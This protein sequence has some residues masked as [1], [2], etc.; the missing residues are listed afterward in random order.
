MKYKGRRNNM[1]ELKYRDAYILVELSDVRI[2]LYSADKV[3]FEDDEAYLEKDMS[4]SALGT[5]SNV[6]DYVL[7]VGEVLDQLR[8]DGVGMAAVDKYVFLAPAQRYEFDIENGVVVSKIGDFAIV[9]CGVIELGEEYDTI[10]AVDE[11]D[12][13]LGEERYEITEEGLK[14]LAEMAANAISD[15]VDELCEDTCQCAS[16]ER[17]ENS[18]MDNLFGNLGFGKL[19]GNRFKLSMN[20]IA[21]AQNTGKYVVYNKENN[22]FVDATNTLF[23]IKDALFLLPAVEVAVGDTVLH[24]DKAYFIV[25]TTNEIKAV[26]YEDCTQTVLIPKSTMF[27]I[28]YFTKVFSMFGDNFAA[29]GDLFSNPMMLMALM[30]GKNSDLSQLMLLSSLSNGDLG[31]NPMAL[32]MMLKGDKSDDAMSTIA[33]MSLFNNGTNPFAPKKKAT[34]NKVTETK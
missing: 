34:T 8:R 20:G 26:S 18:T 30:E 5:I 19:R 32:A 6:L 27:G 29:A 4:F 10:N 3:S 16:E 33:M 7:N 22:E 28:K 25:D 14:Y 15:I 2:P 9:Y 24:E 17:E 23:D 12:N 31:S 13:I 21:V 11:Y 1:A